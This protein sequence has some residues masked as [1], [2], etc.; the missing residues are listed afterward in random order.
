MSKMSFLNYHDHPW[1]ATADL[2][3]GVGKGGGL[4]RIENSTS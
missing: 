3:V 4:G 2:V 1:R